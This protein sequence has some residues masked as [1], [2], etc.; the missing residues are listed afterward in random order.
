MD[1]DSS[2]LDEV[3]PGN[4]LAGG[5]RP[6]HFLVTISGDRVIYPS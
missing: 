1:L 3:G 6:S 4:I 2:L 5:S